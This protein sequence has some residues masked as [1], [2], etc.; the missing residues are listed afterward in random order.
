MAQPLGKAVWRLFRKLKIGL[1]CDLGIQL[2]GINLD[3]DTIQ[4]DT[5]TL[6]FIATPFTIAETWRQ[7]KCPSP[8]EWIKKIGYLYT[9]DYITH[10]Q[11]E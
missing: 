3:K 8:E 11:K 7:P 4:K 9:K 6:L 1:L 10:P 2:L 5:C